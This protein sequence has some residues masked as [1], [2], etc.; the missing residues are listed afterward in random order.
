MTRINANIEPIDLID[1]HLLAEYRELIRIPNHVIKNNDINK[2]NNLPK[3]FV[4]GQGHVKYFYNKQKYL[5]KRF[6][7]IKQE[8]SKRNI[9]NNITDDLFLNVPEYLYND[10]EYHDLYNGNKLIV[11]RIRERI[12]TM[13]TM[14]KLNHTLIKFEEYI[15]HLTQ[16]YN[17]N[18]DK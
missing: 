12:L 9:I 18:Y 7:L 16:K 13:K 14:P 8:L 1:Q 5:H 11:E 2:Y 17:K 15:K 6:L 3:D 10:I 4:L